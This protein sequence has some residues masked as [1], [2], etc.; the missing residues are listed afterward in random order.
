MAAGRPGR[1]RAVNEEEILQDFRENPLTSIPAA[2]NLMRVASY[3]KVW[4]VLRDTQLRFFHF[5]MV[6]ALIPT[7]YRTCEQSI[8]WFLRKETE[9]CLFF[10]DEAYFTPG[11]VFN[12][13]DFHMWQNDNSHV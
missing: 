2:S 8:R 6:Q 4:R 3:S 11:G 5:L 12:T 7:D 1:I 13:R 9:K 10:T